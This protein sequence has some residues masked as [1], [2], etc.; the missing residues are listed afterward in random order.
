MEMVGSDIH[1]NRTPAS[2]VQG[3]SILYHDPWILV[4]DKPHGILSVPGKRVDVADCIAGQLHR[5]GMRP[6]IVHRLDRDTSGVLLFALDRETQSILNRMFAARQ[7]EK[8]YVAILAGHVE[9]DAGTIA[10]P[11]RRDISVSLPPRYVID[12]HGCK[13]ARTTWR[14]LRRDGASTR[15]ELRP[16]TGRSHQLRVHC[17]AM[18]HAI[19]GDPIYGHQAARR[20]MLHAVCLS[21]SHPRTNGR[22]AITAPD[23]F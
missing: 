9:L 6:L 10:W 13:P 8:R 7:I 18:G 1:E 2:E 19:V 21:L 23:A 14:V 4:V 12:E 20:M 11:I 22:L 15:V 17:A 3:L 16:F 5:N